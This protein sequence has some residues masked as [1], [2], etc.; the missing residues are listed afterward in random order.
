VQFIYVGLSS[1]AVA[2]LMVCVM[3]RASACERLNS[4]RGARAI[5]KVLRYSVG[6]EIRQVVFP[7]ERHVWTRVWG[8]WCSEQV[9]LWFRV[10]VSLR[11]ELLAGGRP[12]SAR[13][14]ADRGDIGRAKVGEVRPERGGVEEAFG[15][16][17]E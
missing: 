10:S 8:F 2:G 6:A 4:S 9:I 14:A 17:H 7:G 11:L 5:H 13:I 12:G 15:A 16:G 3:R 1:A